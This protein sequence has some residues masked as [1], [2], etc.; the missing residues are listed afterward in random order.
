ML[1]IPVA[2]LRYYAKYEPK[3]KERLWVYEFFVCFDAL[4]REKKYL[5]L[6]QKD[7]S[8]EKCVLE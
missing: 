7:F 6:E 3:L 2:F 8:A 4:S 1:I 5:N